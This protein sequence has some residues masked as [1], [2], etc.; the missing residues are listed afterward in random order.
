MRNNIYNTYFV[1]QL[2]Q[3]ILSKMY[4]EIQLYTKDI[5]DEISFTE[6]EFG[7]FYSSI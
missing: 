2:T 3:Y 4:W 1:Y 7:H 6:L 5:I